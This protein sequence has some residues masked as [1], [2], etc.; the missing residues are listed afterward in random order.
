MGEVTRLIITK[1]RVF[2]IVKQGI[3]ART[4]VCCVMI[5]SKSTCKCN[6]LSLIFGNNITDASHDLIIGVGN[7]I[8]YLFIAY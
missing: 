7:N 5:V 3:G 1:G 4:H 8:M 2:E 6:I